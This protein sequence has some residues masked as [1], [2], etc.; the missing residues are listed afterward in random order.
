MI[1]SATILSQCIALIP[2]AASHQRIR[3]R[4]L[5]H[6]HKKETREPSIKDSPS[7]TKEVAHK[8]VAAVVAEAHIHFDL[9]IACIMAARQTIA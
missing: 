6:L 3:R 5:G 9:R 1:A 2:M 8:I 4:I 7:T